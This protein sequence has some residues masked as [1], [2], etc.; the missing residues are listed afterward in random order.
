[1]RRDF[2]DKAIHVIFLGPTT[3]L[4][5]ENYCAYYILYRSKTLTGLPDFPLDR[6]FIID[7]QAASVCPHTAAWIY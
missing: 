5:L 3:L 2:C 6:K 1:M 7:L 4:I